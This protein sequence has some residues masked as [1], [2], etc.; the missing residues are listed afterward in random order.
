MVLSL[1][2][3]DPGLVRELAA[4][5]EMPA[6]AG[7]LK[8]AAIV[9]T[10]APPAVYVS[11]NWPTLWTALQPD[12]HGYLCWDEIRPGSYDRYE[13]DISSVQGAPI[14]RTLSEA[15][16]RVAVLDVPHAQIEPVNGVML[17]EYACHDRHRTSA[18]YPAELIGELAERHGRPFGMADPPFPQ[19]APCDYAYRAGA[20]RTAEE[21][22]ALVQAFRESIEIKRNASLDVLRR[23][24][25]DLFMA[26][27][28]ESHCVGHQFWHLHDQTHERHDAALTSR[29]GG[30][31]V[32]DVYRR[33]DRVVADHLAALGPGDTAY[34]TL[35]HGMTAHHDGT[36]VLDEVL[37]RLDWALDVPD[38]LG[39][40]TRAAAQALRIV[41]RPLRGAALRGAAAVVRARGGSDA[42]GPLPPRER[43]R[44]FQVPNNTVV[45]AVRLNLA[46]R[47]PLGRIGPADR[48]AVLQ[49]LSDRLSEL[50]NV[51]TGGA[52]V[53]RCL[54]S[55]D[56]FRRRAGDAFADLYVEWER[57]SP[58]ERVWSPSLGSI[59]VPYE[60]WRQ[61][62]HVREGITLATGPGIKPGRRRGAF[63]VADLGATYAAAAGTVLE[64]VDGRPIASILP[65]GAPRVARR[66]VPSRA[67]IRERAARAPRAPDWASHDDPTLQE[68]IAGLGHDVRSA[69][70]RAAR[71]GAVAVQAGSLAAGA[72]TLAMQADASAASA[73]ARADAAGEREARA[74]SRTEAA[75]QRLADL[76]ARAD[77]ALARE[78]QAVA[79]RDA[80]ADRV[81]TLERLGEIATMSAWLEQAEIPEAL[82]VSV[83][84]PTRNRRALLGPAIAS[85]VA[86][87]YARWELVVIDD[88]STDDTAAFLAGLDDP[89][90]RVLQTDGAGACAA[91]NRGI[92]AA[93][94]DVVAYLDD[95]NRFDP[96]W[97]KAVVATFEARP[98]ARCCYGARV[99]DDEGRLDGGAASG[100]PWIHYAKWDAE[101]VKLYNLVDMNVIAHRRGTARFD[102]SLAYHGDWDL[103]LQLAGDG[104]PVEIPAIGAF[105]RTDVPGRLSDVT[106]QET[107]EDEIAVIQ[108][109][110]AGI[111]R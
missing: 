86:Q 22:E 105:Y 108:R 11:A 5:G 2:A 106:S 31:P 72:N 7:L 73:H 30:D 42:P 88:G 109:R 34:V 68:T 40:A 10:L 75:E 20:H 97:I 49:W 110:A 77:E 102:E 21:S 18:S 65:T 58:I 100:R 46:G 1:D 55:D 24:G 28:G 60:H 37:A 93:S 52:V 103:L 79:E 98:D 32:R 64:D 27:M 44:W 104:D 76:E 53:R 111:N 63:S 29:L 26:V 83:V 87:S 70:E 61:G 4:A 14:W 9:D 38:G 19:F 13:T 89:R 99:I 74:C 107:M 8:R 15:G 6:M 94:G 16:R 85:V 62:D 43:R 78:L 57:D 101:S 33:L 82:L 23:G 84:M 17:L 12:R 92:A 67:R 36:H 91:R 39:P 3:A 95:D 41:P 51:A 47:E 50:V 96:H 69:D 25:W 80:L 71:A 48:R 35:A 59:T 45:G 54:V 90:I 56:V 81:R 66:P